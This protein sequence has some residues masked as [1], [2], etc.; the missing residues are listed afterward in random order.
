MKERSALVERTTEPL[1]E[2]PA[3]ESLNSQPS[4][5]NRSLSEYQA[6]Q[7]NRRER[8]LLQVAELTSPDRKGGALSQNRAAKVLGE[9]AS[10]ICVWKQKFAKGGRDALVPRQADA[11]GRKAKFDLDERER[12]ALRHCRLRKDSLPLAIEDFIRDPE[13][14]QET[15]EK[16]LA[17]MDAAAR[18]RR[19]P[20]WPVS[21]Q[22][23]GYVSE[24][25]QAQFEGKKHAQQFE[26]VERRGLFWI[27]E[28]RNEL[29][30]VGNTL[31]ESDDM[32][33]NKPFRYADPETGAIQVGRQTLCTM[34]VYSAA[35]LGVSPIGRE[36]DAYRLEDIADHLLDVV[37]EQGVPLI[38]R[39]E[40]GPWENQ[41]VDG[42]K[43]PQPLNSSTSQPQRWG[44]LNEIFKVV[45]VFKSRSK[46]LI[47]SSFDL[48][49]ALID[50]DAAEDGLTIGRTRGQFEHA[51][52]LYNAATDAK[53]SVEKRDAAA[54]HFWEIGAAANGIAGA[55]E[56]FNERPKIRRAFGRDAVVPNDLQRTAERRECP[57]SELWRFSPIKKPATVRG[58]AIETSVPHYPFPFRFRVNG[59]SDLY[60]ER[61]YQVLIAFHPGRPEEGC[62][63]FN[64]ETGARN[65]EGLRFGELMFVAPMAE[66]APQLNLRPDE[67]EF[68]ARKNS[69]AAVRS[70]FRAIVA[71]GRR[72][73]RASTVRNGFGDSTTLRAA[74]CGVRANPETGVDISPHAS[75]ASAI[76]FRP[77]ANNAEIPRQIPEEPIGRKKS[78]AHAASHFDEEK[79]LARV[80]R[81]ERAA[82]DRGD[83]LVT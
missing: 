80:A 43:L 11:C 62:H 18:E 31:F 37:S 23:A 73:S 67:K 8:I 65:R 9:P 49:Q 59:C 19:L 3:A 21:I 26:I 53:C 78:N 13:C 30:I 50:H 15:R 34:N 24:D 45:H 42:I 63:V 70:E 69:N 10:V 83:I 77:T 35:W 1:V 39:F 44:S 4:T 46:G 66:D 61:G 64:A 7:R 74:G 12:N 82:I 40:R 47:E 72:P 54:A 36:R 71:T 48:L 79:E 32:S 52:K 28:N 68:L 51:T 2:S 20:H 33:C 76:N 81:L 58:G 56:R 57:A 55:M 22:R 14:R 5:L 17:E 29:P 75:P 38:W 27:D 41:V 60:L 16:I 25:L 6:I